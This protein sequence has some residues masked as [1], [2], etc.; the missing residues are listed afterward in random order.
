MGIPAITGESISYH[1]IELA[2]EVKYCKY[3]T[4]VTEACKCTRFRITP[5]SVSVLTEEVEEQADYH[6]I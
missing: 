5:L 6:M 1:R 2:G 3:L 4:S